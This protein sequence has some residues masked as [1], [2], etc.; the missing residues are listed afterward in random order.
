VDLI[1]AV[2]AR[3]CL[4]MADCA[5]IGDARA[6]VAAGADIVGTTMAGYTG[7]PVPARPDLG[8]VRAAAGLGVPVLAEGR[9]NTPEMAA[10][11]VREGALAVVVGSAITRPENITAWYARAIAAA[12]PVA[13]LALDI[14]GSKSSAA[15][16]EGGAIRRRVVLPTARGAG[17]G[18]WLDALA[19]A[20][21]DWGHQA[22]AA[23]V[24]GVVRD[25]TWS[26][27]NPATLPVPD[28]F[29]ILAALAARFGVP[30]SALNDAQAAAWGEY[31]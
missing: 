22:V 15:L 23:A 26:A 30:A 2:H 25:G 6:A 13:V 29:P 1:A 21:R 18:A 8:F 4:A 9:F 19:L 27:V 24:S 11:A 31:R 10:A 14:G 17:P 7:G 12:V 16:V 3:G 28:G 20:T 5:D